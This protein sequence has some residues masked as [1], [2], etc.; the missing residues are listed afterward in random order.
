[1][2][3]A[4]SNASRENCFFHCLIS[5]STNNKR[6]DFLPSIL[7]SDGKMFHFPNHV[8]VIKLW[9]VKIGLCDTTNKRSR[10]LPCGRCCISMLMHFIFHA[11]D[12]N[13]YFFRKMGR[14]HLETHFLLPDSASRQHYS[15]VTCIIINFSL[16]CG[17]DEKPREIPI[18][19]AIKKHKTQQPEM[20]SSFK[21]L[22]N[23]T[24]SLIFQ[25]W[26]WCLNNKLPLFNHPVFAF[27]LFFFL[28]LAL[29]FSLSQ[30]HDMSF[31]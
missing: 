1:M 12:T 30:L 29:C 11:W 24:T 28:S 26:A 13:T 22:C 10:P 6:R 20:D 23:M 2:S 21:A 25:F 27:L 7:A 15:R 8:S 3:R 18:F 9:N 14:A 5:R 17:A 31:H 4:V 19:L 16:F